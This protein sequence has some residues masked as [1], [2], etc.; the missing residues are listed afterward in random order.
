MNSPKNTFLDC[1]FAR[2]AER[3]SDTVDLDCDDVRERLLQHPHML[4]VLEKMEET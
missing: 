4:A 1:V 2:Y 3:F